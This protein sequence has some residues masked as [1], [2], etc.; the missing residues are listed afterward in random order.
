MEALSGWGQG[1]CAGLG[2][3]WSLP[4]T[5]A[6]FYSFAF[7][8][9]C[10]DSLWRWKK[11]PSEVSL[12]A[13]IHPDP[14]GPPGWA[15]F[16]DC[17]SLEKC[18]FPSHFLAPLEWGNTRPQSIISTLQAVCPSVWKRIFKHWNTRYYPQGPHVPTDRKTHLVKASKLPECWK[19][20]NLKQ[21]NQRRQV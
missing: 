8:G 16:P 10:D 1:R 17:G 3:V 6:G 11:Q 18:H 5:C 21:C 14:R 13:Q 20:C 4:L 2:E 15:H 12:P 19:P 7:Y 9:C